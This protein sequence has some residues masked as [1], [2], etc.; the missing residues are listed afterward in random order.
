[1]HNP[2]HGPSL[3]AQARACT[4]QY[5]PPPRDTAWAMSEENVEIVRRVVEEF[6]AGLGRGD[7]GAFFDSPTGCRS[8]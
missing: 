4:S 3:G 7:P 2:L 5:L 6:Q 1:V 8:S